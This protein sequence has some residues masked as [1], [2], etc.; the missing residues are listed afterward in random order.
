MR[1]SNQHTQSPSNGG[2]F[3]TLK[4]QISQKIR[5]LNIGDQLRKDVHLLNLV[6][7]KHFHV[8]WS[9]VSHPLFIRIQPI[10]TVR[11]QVAA[12]WYKCHF[13]DNRIHSRCSLHLL[14]FFPS[15]LLL[16]WFHLFYSDQLNTLQS[17]MNAHECA[18]RNMEQ[19]H[20]ACLPTRRS[21]S[22]FSALSDECCVFCPPIPKI[23]KIECLAW[24]ETNMK[25]YNLQVRERTEIR[26]KRIFSVPRNALENM[27]DCRWE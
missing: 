11:I 6:C 25:L 20:A 7:S 19:C 16:S 10:R 18:Y 12:N 5:N 8:V 22:L 4:F 13:R 1:R 15:S 2:Y 3:E 24:C 26:I 27:V 21:W 14:L 9:T 23:D 17:P